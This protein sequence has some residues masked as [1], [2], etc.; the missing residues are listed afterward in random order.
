MRKE[1]PISDETTIKIIYLFLIIGI[2][3]LAFGS[4]NIYQKNILISDFN[5]VEGYFIGSEER[6]RR[7]RD[8][9]ISFYLIY[10]YTVD[11]TTYQIKTDYSTNRVPPLG[12]TR[13]I[14]Y[15]P[16]NPED[17]IITGMSASHILIIIGTG[18]IFLSSL[19]M[20]SE[21]RRKKMLN[22]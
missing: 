1:I 4:F 19:S 2:L 16:A 18:F 3:L 22:N 15:N 7:N 20:I 6:E 21:K 9:N 13:I 14:R 11:G 5:S 8:E 17:A 10:S 12:S